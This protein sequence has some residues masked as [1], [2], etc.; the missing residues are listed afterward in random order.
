MELPS[1][2]DSKQSLLSTGWNLV[3]LFN[4]LKKVPNFRKLMVASFLL[5]RGFSFYVYMAML[6]RYMRYHM[7]YL[8]LS[9]YSVATCTSN[10]YICTMVAVRIVVWTIWALPYIMFCP[11]AINVTGPYWSCSWTIWLIRLE[12]SPI[13]L[14]TQRSTHNCSILCSPLITITYRTPLLSII[15]SRIIIITI[16]GVDF[17]SSTVLVWSINQPGCYL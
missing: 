10:S 11:W 8:Y 17:Y 16:T 3:K 14:I 2:N 6:N 1:S 9:I 12:V 13:K 5:H 7:T 4:Y 15:I